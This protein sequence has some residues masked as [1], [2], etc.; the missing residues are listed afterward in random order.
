MIMRRISKLHRILKPALKYFLSKMLVTI[1]LTL[2]NWS[3]RNLNVIY[4]VTARKLDV[5]LI[6]TEIVHVTILDVKCVTSVYQ[7][8][9]TALIYSLKHLD[10]DVVTRLFNVMRKPKHVHCNNR[11]FQLA[12]YKVLKIIEVPTEALREA[13]AEIG[14]SKVMR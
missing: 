2:G 5:A 11:F 9:G 4:V 3:Y 12:L 10:R 14:S 13:L 7:R 1:S 8:V 6:T